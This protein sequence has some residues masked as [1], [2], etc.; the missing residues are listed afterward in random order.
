MINCLRAVQCPLPSRS[1]SK[2]A[3]MAVLKTFLRKGTWPL[4][5]DILPWKIMGWQNNKNN[6]SKNVHME[7]SGVSL[8]RRP[9][10]VIYDR[11]NCL[12]HKWQLSPSSVQCLCGHHLLFI[13]PLERVLTR[14]TQ[15]CPHFWEWVTFVYHVCTVFYRSN[16]IYGIVCCTNWV[17]VMYVNCV[18]DRKTFSIW[19][20]VGINAICT[21]LLCVG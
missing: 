19:T 11:W 16:H 1:F 7:W 9:G 12:W 21:T 8:P 18:A 15:A 5:W 4:F 17:G 10:Q 13:T 2:C 3:Y 6:V 14:R 20:S